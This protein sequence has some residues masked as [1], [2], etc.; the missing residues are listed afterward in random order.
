MRKENDGK[1][2]PSYSPRAWRVG[3]KFKY[4]VRQSVE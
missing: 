2:M 4:A 1:A 3:Q